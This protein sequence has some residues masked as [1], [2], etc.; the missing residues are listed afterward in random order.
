MPTLML[1]GSPFSP[2]NEPKTLG[3]LLAAADERCAGQRRIVTAVRLDGDDEPAFRE[4]HVVSRAVTTC[5][6]V[7]ITSG[8]AAALA[9]EC[10]SEAGIALAELSA[11]S[12]DV[13]CRLRAGDIRGANRDLST[14]T[15]GIGTAV[16]ITG[17]ASLGL[18][19]DLGARE[20]SHGSLSHLSDRAAKHLEAV[21]AAQVAGTWDAVADALEHGLAPD[22]R[23]WGDICR[24]LDVDAMPTPDP[25]PH[26]EHA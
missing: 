6:S 11:A 8:T 25:V 7:E 26:E 22:L 20:T 10:L 5:R 3:D 21:I 18:G 9:Q 16:A 1:D 2:G 19:L 17:A 14:I 4:P 12:V 15:Q 13:A 23:V 24:H